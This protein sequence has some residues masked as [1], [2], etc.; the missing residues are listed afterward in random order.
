M[1]GR[2]HG[3]CF[4]ILAQDLLP[5]TLRNPIQIPIKVVGVRRGNE[6]GNT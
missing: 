5:G 3:L 2:G 4:K 1:E 6:P